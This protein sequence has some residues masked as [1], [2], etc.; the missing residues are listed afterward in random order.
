MTA[1]GQQKEVTELNR[2]YLSLTL[3]SGCKSLP[4]MVPQKR[5][6]DNKPSTKERDRETHHQ[7]AWD[8]SKVRR[9]CATGRLPAC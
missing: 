1:R 8:Q 9:F 6:T 7:S 5:N 2:I 3:P 4:T